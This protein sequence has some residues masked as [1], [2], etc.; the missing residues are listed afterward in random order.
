MC[1][2]AFLCFLFVFRDFSRPD[3]PSGEGQPAFDPNLGLS[4]LGLYIIFI[5]NLPGYPTVHK[6]C[7]TE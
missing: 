2:L 7:L 4:A 6:N 1:N 5:D 3:L